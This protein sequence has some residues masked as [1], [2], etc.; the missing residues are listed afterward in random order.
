MLFSNPFYSSFSSFF[1]K[2]VLLKMIFDQYIKMNNT[3]LNKI[4]V[5]YNTIKQ[6]KKCCSK[7]KSSEISTQSKQENSK[8]SNKQK[9]W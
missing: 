9:V 3:K 7:F 1:K 2:N 4:Y 8:N 5:I 6:P